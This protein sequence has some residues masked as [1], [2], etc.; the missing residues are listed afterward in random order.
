[1]YN[2]NNLP[3]SVY[4]TAEEMQ[5]TDVKNGTFFGLSCLFHQILLAA[6]FNLLYLLRW[7]RK[8]CITVLLPRYI[9]IDTGTQC[10]INV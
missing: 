7:T 4:I 2:K 10:I 3:N 9:T 8:M 6:R 1:M 5:Q